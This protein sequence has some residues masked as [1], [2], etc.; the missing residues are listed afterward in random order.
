MHKNY[1]LFERQAQELKPLLTGKKIISVFTYRKNEVIFHLAGEPSVFLMISVDI[2]FPYF[3]YRQAQNIRPP[4]FDLFDELLDEVITDIKIIP[5]DK[6]IMLETD[7]HVC[8]CIFFGNQPNLF[9]FDKSGALLASFKEGQPDFIQPKSG[10]VDLRGLNQHGFS[11]LVNTAADQ[12]LPEFLKSRFAAISNLLATELIFRARCEAQLLLSE[13]PDTTVSRLFSAIKDIGAELTAGHVFLYYR[14]NSLQSISFVRLSH[15]EGEP[16]VH[17]REFDTVNQAWTQFINEKTEKLKFEKLHR[18]C[19]QALSKRRQ[20]LTNVLENIRQMED[21]AERKQQAELKGNL[22]LTFKHTIKAGRSEVELENIFSDTS[23][24]IM[25]KLNPQKTIV[26]NANLYFNKYKDIDKKRLIQDIKKNTYLDEL[27]RIEELIKTL[28]NATEYLRLVKMY[29]Q[30][31]NMKLVQ[32]SGA[33]GDSQKKD[34]HYSFT[35]L[36]LEKEW[37]IY[38]GKNGE[39]ND[40]LTFGFANKWDI[41]LHAQGVAGSHVIIRLPRKDFHPPYKVL[42]QAAQLAAAHSKAQHS[43]TAPVIYTE[44][45]YVNRIRKALPGT[46]SV[47]NEKVIFVKPLKMS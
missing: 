33:T 14:K 39:N 20:Y 13:C 8:S 18:L 31:S 38:I 29:K 15:L 27:K 46:V 37:D 34:I 24:K 25:I 47:K 19:A 16:E 45:R 17:A 41:W 22:L 35:R 3:L 44:V 12:K 32:I 6:H 28:E 1:F 23:D 4:K 26:E 42:E 10:L 21:L 36:I 9:L 30:L 43:T 7:K 2:S 5:Y 11:T 40:L